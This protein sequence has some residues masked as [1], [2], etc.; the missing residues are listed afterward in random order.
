MACSVPLRIGALLLA[1]GAL[2]AACG[3]DEART[4][5]TLE[6]A[7]YDFRFEP[8]R[9]TLAPGSEVTLTFTNEGETEHSFTAEE[10]DVD[11]EAEAGE[12]TET[13][14]QPPADAGQVEFFCRYHPDRMTGTI[15]I[16]DA[17]PEET[18]TGGG[19]EQP[20]DDAD[21]DY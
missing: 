9:L 16:G 4:G 19:G 8:D 10:L 21:Y 13:T 14:L 12:S 1:L 11:I 3:E 17:T 18:E 15:A 5:G 2:V 20:R 7:A 6:V